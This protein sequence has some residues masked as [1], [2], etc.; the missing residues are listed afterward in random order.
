MGFKLLKLP[1]G[2]YITPN[3]LAMVWARRK[4]I[5]V[6]NYAFHGVVFYFYNLSFYLF[7]K[8]RSSRGPDD[9]D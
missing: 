6:K 7:I 5:E 8:R 2:N 3:L 1:S 9:T 4:E